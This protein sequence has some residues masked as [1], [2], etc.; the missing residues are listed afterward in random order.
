MLWSTLE[1]LHLIKKEDFAMLKNQKQMYHAL[2][3]LA[4]LNGM[5]IFGGNSD[6]SIPLCELKQAFSL[7]NSIYNRSF[8]D[9]SVTNA[10]DYY[11]T[12]IA[13]LKPESI[14][15]HIGES[16]MNLFLST[17]S[18]FDQKY[19]ALITHIKN[20][21]KKCRIIIV[22]LKNYDNDKD[23]TEMNK[24][25]KYI[26]NSEHCEYADI[27]HKK[28]WNP[29]QTK[30]ITSFIYS[31]GFVRPLKIERPIYDL[32]KILFCFH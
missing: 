10:Q 1:T 30:D 9:L 8:T 14:L 13:D 12:C 21:N 28:I 18:K 2:N 31:T 17:P 7:D 5:I 4:N 20:T 25:L 24:H 6:I 27:S 11:D 32:T 23:T 19:M 16:D 26:A 22:S 29:K 15:L 3:Q